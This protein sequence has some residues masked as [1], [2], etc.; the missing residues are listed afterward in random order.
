VESPF[1]A[2]YAPRYA[3]SAEHARGADL[4]RLLEWLAVRPGRRAVDVGTGTGHTALALAAAGAEVVGVDP[5]PAMLAEA[6]RLAAQ[7]GLAARVRFVVG[8]AERLPVA[9]GWAD[10]ATCRRAAHH[11]RDVG[12]ALREI[13]RVLRP[14][15]RLGV[16]DMCP[17][18]ALEATVNRLERLRDPTHRRALTDGEWR[19]AVEGAGLQVL[20]AEVST[21]ETT[22][23]AWLAP[24]STDGP[25]A[26]AIRQALEGLAPQQRDAITGG[27][28]GSW[29]K[30]R[31]LLV[32]QVPSR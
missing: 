22:F 29:R 11:F 23:A 31:L 18:P 10:L 14:G 8:E 13:A 3:V 19:A 1:F 5:T 9:D 2:R 4:T 21:E 30:R 6:Q 17:E 28:P 27:V 20:A 32:A 25:E 7:K 26:V 24:V 15:G 16:S 12:Q